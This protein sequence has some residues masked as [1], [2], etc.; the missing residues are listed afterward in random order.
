MDGW[1]NGW[2]N[3]KSLKSKKSWPYW[4]NSIMEILDIYL[5]ILSFTFNWGYHFRRKSNHFLSASLCILLKPSNQLC[6]FNW[7]Y[8]F[9]RKLNHFLPASLYILLKPSNPLASAKS[10][11]IFLTSLP[12]KGNPTKENSSIILTI[13]S[14]NKKLICYSR[15]VGNN[16]MYM[17]RF[18]KPKQSLVQ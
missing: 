9:R 16:N 3:V 8:H 18:N 1:V 14:T 11:A 7:G 2:V 13:L 4:D 12:D 5:D 10:K 15:E 17:I 6:T